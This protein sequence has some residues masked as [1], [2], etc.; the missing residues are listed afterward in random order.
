MTSGAKNFA[1]IDK[2]IGRVARLLEETSLNRTKL[3][4]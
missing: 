1:E 4:F 2:V 3:E